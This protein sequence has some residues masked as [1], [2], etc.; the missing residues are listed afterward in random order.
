MTLVFA[1]IKGSATVD[2]EWYPTAVQ[3]FNRL[4]SLVNQ[5]RMLW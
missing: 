3:F 4:D 2:P 1:G 5:E